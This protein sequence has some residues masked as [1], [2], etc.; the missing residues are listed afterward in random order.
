MKKN[1][2]SIVCPVCK[3]ERK[4]K[5]KI[6][7]QEERKCRSCAG[8]TRPDARGE[9]HPNWRGGIINSN[10]YLIQH[11]KS[12]DKYFSMAS[13]VSKNG[14]GG[15]IIQHRYVMAKHLGRIL[16]SNEVVHHINGIKKDN[17]IE[18]L[19]LTKRGEHKTTYADGFRAG[20][21]KAMLENRKTLNGLEYT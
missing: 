1:K 7:Y 2:I 11:I 19:F 6:P 12:T 8:K 21:E 18:N 16:D 17:R 10:G 9:L 4:V 5:L 14:F 13:V 15:Y 3:K 20:Y